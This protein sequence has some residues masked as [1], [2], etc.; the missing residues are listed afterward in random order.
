MSNWVSGT[1]F[2]C[3]DIGFEGDLICWV[4]LGLGLFE[5]DFVL[6]VLLGIVDGVLE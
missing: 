2:E 6:S 5:F 3:L 1:V 4:W